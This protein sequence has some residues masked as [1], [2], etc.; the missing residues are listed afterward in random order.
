MP[1][2][3]NQLIPFQLEPNT[4]YTLHVR[5][6]SE[7]M[8]LEHVSPNG[9]FKTLLEPGMEHK[10]K[11]EEEFTLVQ[12]TPGRF[13]FISTSCL[14]AA[15]NWFQDMHELEKMGK[16]DPDFTLFIGDLI[17]T[18]VPLWPMGLGTKIEHYFA[19]Y[20]ETYRNTH[21][22]GYVQNSPMFYVS[23]FLLHTKF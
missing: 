19:K 16:H 6:L 18:D 23:A 2:N 3:S 20:R 14:M 12:G 15:E 13:R 21:F 11:S 1:E 22:Q 7:E 9:T 5:F 10:V 17:Y 4:P 8:Q